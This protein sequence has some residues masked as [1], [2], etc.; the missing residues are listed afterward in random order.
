MV[1]LSA[2]NG[3]VA[4]SN[5]ASPEIPDS[6]RRAELERIASGLKLL[7]ER[8]QPHEAQIYIGRA[9]LYERSKNIMA[10]CGRNF[11]KAIDLETDIPT[12][13]GWKKLKDIQPGDYVFDEQGKPTQVLAQSP[14]WTDHKCYE[15]TFS[16]GSTVVV[17]EQHNWLTHSKAERK[18]FRSPSKRTT[19]EIVATLKAGKE[20]NHQI[21]TCEPVQYPDTLLPIA[22]YTLGVWL[23]NGNHTQA[24]LCQW[25]EEVLTQVKADGFQV[26]PHT[27]QH[28]YGVLG[29][30][31][32]L[33]QHGLLKNKHIPKAYL[34][35]SVEQRKALLAGLMDTDGTVNE[36]GVCCFDNTNEDIARGVLELV[37]SLGVR[38]TLKSRFGKFNGKI[39]KL[40]YRVNF[41]PGLQVFRLSRKAQRL[42]PFL[43]KHKR[44]HR[45]IVAAKEVP[46]RP[47]KC[48]TVANPSHLFLVGRQF[49]VTHNSELMAYLLWRWAWTYPGSENY[50][51]APFMKQAREIMWASRRIQSF[52]PWE[53][54][55]SVNDTEMRIRFNNGS[56]IKL[57]GSDNDQA[58]RGIKPRGLVIYDEYKDFRPE[59]HDAMDPNRAAHDAPLLVIGTPP[60]FENHFN[61]M[62][63]D[64]QSSPNKRFF[65]FPTEA[66]PHI[67]KEWLAQKKAEL[68]ARGDGDQWEREYM[69]LNVR[70]GHRSIFPMLDP[71]KHKH[72]HDT[73]IAKI[74]R[75]RKKLEWF[76]WA[77]PAGASC[78]AV[79]FVAIN[80]YTRDIYVLDEIYETKQANMSVK[81]IGERMLAIVD[82]L[83]DVREAWRFGYDEAEA[84]FRNEMLDHF[85]IHFEPT[86]K[87]K[88]D[89]TTGLSLIKDTLLAGKLHLSDRCVKLWWEMENYR[90]DDNGK[91]PKLNDH[92]LDCLRYVF[93]ASY[94]HLNPSEEVL[95]E[96]DPMWRGAKI[97]DD[98]PGMSETGERLDDYGEDW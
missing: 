90:K 38:A 76:A 19:A 21:A 30:L 33:R 80:P 32:L 16:D 91:I 70:G 74:H 22:P 9:L 93:S 35:A 79:L 89:K 1:E 29:L 12:P 27:K 8:W 4:G 57:E 7:H 69:A 47:V 65:R 25:D 96:S 86:Q 60:E 34:T 95:K 62:Q 31:P 67:S 37:H 94:Y 5:P 54:V 39:H 24:T 63:A 61:V 3:S 15:L 92:A 2:V 11:G 18:R 28:S 17:D 84:W 46:P 51:F 97:E 68:Y 82:D 13:E 78:F 43:N 20:Y 75:D 45:A 26:S 98:F 44:K 14:V 59:F 55:E 53:W 64:F 83:Y 49:L 42:E 81:N 6:V 71:S 36:V 58:L 77:D 52:G 40:C 48:L 56:F 66:N 88:S 85:S 41:S 50:Y 87:A 23:G 73:L 72:P 10:V